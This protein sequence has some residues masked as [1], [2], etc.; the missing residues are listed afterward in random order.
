MLKEAHWFGMLERLLLLPGFIWLEVV[1]IY[2]TGDK[3]IN[4]IKNIK[5]V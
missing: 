3:L 1:A 4:G 2:F 5:S